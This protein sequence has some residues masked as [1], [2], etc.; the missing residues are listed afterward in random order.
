MLALDGAGE[1]VALATWPLNMIAVAVGLKQMTLS[2]LRF[3]ESERLLPRDPQRA[4]ALV[5]Y[6]TAS[7]ALAPLHLPALYASRSA[8]A[9]EFYAGAVAV[10]VV[11][12]LLQFLLGSQ[13]E[14]HF[15]WQLIEM[16]KGQARM[17]GVVSAGI[18]LMTALWYCAALPAMFIY[19]GKTLET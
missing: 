1:I 14:A 4:K 2:R 11:V 19:I 3:L 10:H 13:A 15:L 16:P 18:R 9:E 8:M 6:L 7:L 17:M 5:S 12:L